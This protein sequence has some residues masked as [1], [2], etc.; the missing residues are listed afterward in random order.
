M[1]IPA[2]EK[3]MELTFPEENNLPENY[4]PR[5]QLVGGSVVYLELCMHEPQEPRAPPGEKQNYNRLERQQANPIS[6]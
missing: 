3:G 4:A 5:K 2:L 1:A 6:K